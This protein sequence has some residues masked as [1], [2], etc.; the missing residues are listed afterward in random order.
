MSDSPSSDRKINWKR[1]VLYGCGS[2]LGAYLGGMALQSP[3]GAAV[4]ASLGVLAA[5][6]LGR[7]LEKPRQ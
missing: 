7:L 4:G 1:N 3:W 5:A 2:G 6:L